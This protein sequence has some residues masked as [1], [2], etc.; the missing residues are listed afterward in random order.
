MKKLAV[1]QL[2]ALLLVV[3]LLF[4]MFTATNVYSEVQSR[5][6]SVLCLSCIK[7]QP[8]TDKE[9]SFTTA[10]GKPHP[11]F[12]L[13]NITKGPIFIDYSAD[14]CKACD[15]MAPIVKQY[16]NNV[17]YNK[18]DAFHK[19]ITIN[20]QNITYIYINIDHTTKEK[21]DSLDTYDKANASGLP[22]F[23]FITLGYDNGII[24]P[25]YTSI[26]GVQNIQLIDSLVSDMI[27]LYN[28]NHE[29]YVPHH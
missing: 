1:I 9:F 16:F 29:G 26:Y 19:T 12:V 27:E 6:V 4:G 17:S 20:N 21:Y 28:Q 23:T 2:T 11:P 15:D 7:L 22:M 8:K 18:T 14:V 10:N 5:I 25:Y 13:E 3:G 24:K